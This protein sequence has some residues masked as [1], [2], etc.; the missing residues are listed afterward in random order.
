MKSK[1]RAV[2]TEYNGEI[3]DSKKEARYAATLD[4]MQKGKL[5]KDI[6]RQVVFAWTETHSENLKLIVFKRKYIADFT[7]FDIELNE[8]IIVDVK[9]FRTSEYKK[10]KKIVEAI[11][12]I[13]I[14]EI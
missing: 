14:T 5:I 9:G 4:F 1:Y 6:K 2:K 10:K 12:E 13:K 7:Y 8:T 11:F 3:Y